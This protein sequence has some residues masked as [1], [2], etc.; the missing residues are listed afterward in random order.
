MHRIS[1]TATTATID[2]IWYSIPRHKWPALNSPFDRNYYQGG[3]IWNWPSIIGHF[4][5]FGSGNLYSVPQYIL[6]C[7]NDINYYDIKYYDN[8]SF[9]TMPYDPCGIDRSAEY[10]QWRCLEQD[11][12]PSSLNILNKNTFFHIGSVPLQGT[13][14]FFSGDDGSCT[15]DFMGFGFPWNDDICYPIEF[16]GADA[17]LPNIAAFT[18]PDGRQRVT[19]INKAGMFYVFEVPSRELIVSKKVGLLLY[20][21]CTFSVIS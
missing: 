1:M 19:G 21:L 3:G 7:M 16:S 18:T 9:N 4:L 20:R 8:F 13:D 6:D 5:V 15:L 12:H 10:P 2:A 11:V 14:I 17:D